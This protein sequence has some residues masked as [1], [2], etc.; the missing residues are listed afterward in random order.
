MSF[1]PAA[2]YVTKTERL[3]NS[4]KH[5]PVSSKYLKD[6]I[7]AVVCFALCL[8][9][10]WTIEIFS[11][12]STDCLECLCFCKR[13]SLVWSKCCPISGVC[14]HFANTCFV[15][16]SGKQNLIS[17]ALLRSSDCVAVWLAN[18]LCYFAG[19]EFLYLLRLSITAYAVWF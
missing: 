11:L 12:L 3:W 1:K 4:D 15:W 16:S 19:T 14:L 17:T 10:G 8:R 7:L 18:D 13:L 5:L 2:C 6:R 9:L